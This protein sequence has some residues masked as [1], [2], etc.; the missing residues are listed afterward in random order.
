M[1]RSL[2][3]RWWR[4]WTSHPTRSA[5]PPGHPESIHIVR[6]ELWAFRQSAKEQ[7]SIADRPVSFTVMKTCSLHRQLQVDRLPICEGP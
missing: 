6:L 1:E 7:C 5:P 4:W 3:G 2:R